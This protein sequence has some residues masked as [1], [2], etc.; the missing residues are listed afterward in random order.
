MCANIKRWKIVRKKLIEH[1]W[2]WTAFN[3]RNLNEDS[4]DFPR[5]RWK[6]AA[7]A[8]VKAIIKTAF[9]RLRVRNNVAAAAAAAAAA[10]QVEFKGFEV[11]TGLWF[12][13]ET[14][15]TS[16]W[17]DEALDLWP[18]PRGAGRHEAACL[19][20]LALALA[21]ATHNL[22]ACVSILSRAYSSPRRKH[23]AREYSDFCDFY[24][25]NR[26]KLLARILLAE[27]RKI[28]STILIEYKC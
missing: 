5:R 18:P 26:Y 11:K 17:L 7:S 27:T 10:R 25:G 13:A 15:S 1:H 14:G 24:T 9:L 12:Q 16:S 4:G 21:L 19:L 23:R 20:A 8:N 3:R 2:F 28:D 22:Q 6:V